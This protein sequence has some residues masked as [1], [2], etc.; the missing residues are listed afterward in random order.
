M[1]ELRGAGG[2]P[3]GLGAFFGGCAVSG[4]GLYLLFSRVVVHSGGFWHGV[5][6]SGFGQGGGI[7]VILAPFVLGIALLFVDGISKLGW[8]LTI[9]SLLML[10]LEIVTSLR[11]AFAPTSL[12]LLLFI[13][14]LVGAGMGLVIRSLRAQ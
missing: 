6:G 1:A 8:G 12:P 14:G 7:A 11:I 4:L 13:L 2:T 3:G 5:V 9:A 10:L